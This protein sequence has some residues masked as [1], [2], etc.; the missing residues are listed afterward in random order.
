MGTVMCDWTQEEVHSVIRFLRAKGTAP[1]EI[2]REIERVYGCNV[3]TVQ[4]VRKWCLGFSG[5]RV[6][7]T[8]EQ[9][10]RRPSTS[11]DLVPAVENIVCANRPVFLKELGEQ[12]NF[13]LGTVWDI[14]HERLGYRKVCSRWV[15]QQLT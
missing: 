5:G 1:T 13:S 3:T 12:F 2:H 15:P 9:R 6:S 4:H 10:S 7:V 11:A 14:V 8:D